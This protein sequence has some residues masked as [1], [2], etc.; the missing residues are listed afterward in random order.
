MNR[1][2]ELADRLSQWLRQDAQRMSVLAVV[3]SLNLP[4]GYIGAGFVRNLVWDHLHDFTQQTPLNDVDVVYFDRSEQTQENA[5][6]IEAQLNRDYPFVVWQVR[7]QALM[8]TRNGD[9]PYTST[10]D[11]IR[12]WVEC[13]T[14]VAARCVAG[15]LEIIAGFGL[16]S[17]FAGHLT[18]NTRRPLATFQTRVEEKQWL[19]HWPQLKVV[20]PQ[21]R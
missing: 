4:Q 16:A 17:L 11:A 20:L 5:W 21:G 9:Q 3:E 18:H 6:Q 19:K 2:A 10:L 14:A 7:N 15:D 8:H 12:H 1:E 13:E